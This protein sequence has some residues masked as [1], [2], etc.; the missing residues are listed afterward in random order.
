MKEVY[1]IKPAAFVLILALFFPLFTACFQ[2]QDTPSDTT[3]DTAP[4]KTFSIVEGGASEYVIVRGD[5]CEKWETDAAILFRQ[6]VEAITGVA[7]LL[8]TDWEKPGDKAKRP[9]NEI[10]IGATN[11]EGSESDVAAGNAEYSID[12]SELGYRNF[13][14]KTSGEK[15]II[16]AGTETGMNEAL[17][18]FFLQYA[19][20]DIN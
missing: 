20:Y 4:A 1:M 2:T 17:S 5:T 8:T 11:R 3:A 18:Y 16:V 10:I 7:L 19:N 14:I 15:I 13:T 12:R 9:A 6:T